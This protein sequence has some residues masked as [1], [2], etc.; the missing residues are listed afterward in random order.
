[1]KKK[2]SL[3]VD[4]AKFVVEKY[5]KEDQELPQEETEKTKKNNTKVVDDI[6]AILN[7]NDDDRASNEDEPNEDGNIDDENIDDLLKEYKKL[8][9]NY[10]RLKND[11]IYKRQ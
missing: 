6:D 3:Y 8:E 5:N 10:W 1:M 9:K 11:K 7:P 2:T 4:F